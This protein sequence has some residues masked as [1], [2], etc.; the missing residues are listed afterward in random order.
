ML[1]NLISDI[2]K[3]MSEVAVPFSLVIYCISLL[4][5]EKIEKVLMPERS[6]IY[7]ML[8][9]ILVLSIPFLIELVWLRPPV[10]G[11]KILELNEY[12]FIVVGG[13]I[14]LG[15]ITYS[16]VQFIIWI[17]DKT[18]FYVYLDKDGNHDGKEWTIVKTTDS[19]IVILSHKDIVSKQTI[20]RFED[21]AKIRDLK[22][23]GMN[24]KSKKN[25]LS[26]IGIEDPVSTDA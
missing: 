24:G 25:P 3:Y 2:P 9:N 18:Q 21:L 11:E 17:A 20:Y 26:R 8:I 23:W 7:L 1:T 6:K 13:P 14:I 5:K 16:I 12:T 15:G 22:I 4:R 10:K 19:K